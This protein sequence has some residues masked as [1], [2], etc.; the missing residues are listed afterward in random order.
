[1][2]ASDDDDHHALGLMMT[3][4]QAEKAALG[5]VDFDDL[6]ELPA[7]MLAEHPAILATLQRRWRYGLV[8]E[9]QDTNTLQ[10]A[11]ISRL[12]KASGNLCV[13]GDD[14]QSIY[15]WR[16]ADQRNILEFERHFPATTAILLTQNY[17]CKAPILRVANSLIAQN[18][19]RRPKTLEATRGPGEPVRLQRFAD[20]ELEAE[21]IIQEIA[22]LLRT[23]TAP[24]QIAILMRRSA[25]AP[26][27]EAELA[28][29]SVAFRLVG[30]KRMA[31]KK[32]A[33]D[34][35][36]YMQVIGSDRNELA[37]RR[38]ITTPSRGVG[39]V[40][41]EKMRLIA[42]QR[43]CGIAAVS[44]TELGDVRAQ[45]RVAIDE[46]QASI[47]RARS[48]LDSGDPVVA[49]LNE[50]L[51]ANQYRARLGEDISSAKAQARQSDDLDR[52]LEMLH[53]SWS[54]PKLGVRPGAKLNTFVN[55]LT[56]ASGQ[57]DGVERGDEVVL[58]TIHGA[59]GLEFDHVW[60]VGIEEGSLP[61][62]RIIDDG[63]PGELEEERRLLYVAITR[64]R[65]HL[66]LS[67][68]EEIVRGERRSLRLPSRFLAELADAGLSEEV[69]GEAPRRDTVEVA[70][71]RAA[72]MA[73]LAELGVA[74]PER[75]G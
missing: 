19:R 12:M 75:Q 13:V 63:D 1:L 58:S 9:F 18:R 54:D 7:Q 15:G 27:F 44:S 38:A 59:K 21:V 67:Y 2:E 31:D 26:V 17:R 72:L 40:T 52:T 34:L 64:A 43:G 50:M 36:A 49:V 28:R 65:D 37:F 25:Q 53:S 69:I 48:R 5:A 22:R 30:G 10:F 71:D 56:L 70:Q 24:N 45:N 8:D 51:A 39:A 73:R 46:F 4:Y 61:V 57:D 3:R 41:I 55:R 29:R 42:T 74:L 14:D 60:V 11:L 6:I 66:T 23:G 47:K 62:Q 68:S 32:A 35:F 33:R 16:G 20:N